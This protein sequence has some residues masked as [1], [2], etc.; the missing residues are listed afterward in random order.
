M[1]TII[2][3]KKTVVFVLILIFSSTY[4]KAQFG[5]SQTFDGMTQS[6]VTPSGV[7]N[8][9][10]V[11]TIEF[12]VKTTENRSN[13]TYWQRPSMISSA[14]SGGPSGDFGIT[15]DNGYVGIWSGLNS[16]GDNFFL[17][18]TV[19]IND[20]VWHH[21][22]AVNNGNVISLYVDGSF[23]GSVTSG[24]GLAT[25]AAP[26]AIGA[27]SLD[28]GFPG[29]VG[30]C[31]FFH[32][33]SIDEV[34]FS[35]NVR[36]TA[37]FTVPTTAFTTDANTVALY[38]LDGCV[39]GLVTDASGNNNNASPKNL[40]GSCTF[41]L[42]ASPSIPANSAASN[43]SKAE[44]FFDADPGFGSGTNI[45]VAAANDIMV[46]SAAVNLT[47]LI[48]GAHRLSVRTK[49]AAGHWGLTNTTSFF[50][51][52]AI[53][54]IPATPN[55]TQILKAEYFFD[56]DPGF[57][58]A[59][60]IPITASFD[61]TGTFPLSLTGLTTGV[62]RVFLRT[63]DAGGHWSISN[64]AT[65]NIVQGAPVI[66][67]TA[68]AT[69][70]VK[71]EYFIDTDPGFGAATNI[72][73]TAGMD[74]TIN[75]AFINLTGLSNGV[76]RIYTRT[77]DAAGHWSISNNNVFSIIAASF[78]MPSNPVP[79]NITKVEY[80]FDTDPGFGNGT[81]ISV[82]PTTDLSS[83]NFAANITLLSDAQH[84]LY[85]RTY[86]GWGITN[87]KTFIKGALVPL[88]FLSFNAKAAA[89]SV[90]LNWKTANE[91]NVSHFD[92]ER[93][94]D[95][96]I[97]TKIGSTAALNNGT[98]AHDYHFTD[99][100]PLQGISYY[101]IKQIDN[102]G[103]FK[104]SVIVAVKF[105]KSIPITIYPNPAN[106]VVNILF[107]K[108]QDKNT[109]GVLINSGGQIVQRLIFA[110]LQSAQLNV[111]NLASGVYELQISGATTVTQKIIIKH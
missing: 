37:N 31:N 39:S 81:V 28:F 43:V 100:H 66:P 94:A 56:T 10:T 40:T 9:K 95:S 107:D 111:M 17:S 84:T 103:H 58:A 1:Q 34:R 54:G 52:P 7:M 96:R 83:F 4:C 72:P 90:L 24:L 55:A 68:T 46:N 63:K 76:H 22:A 18:N 93:S 89:D 51:V 12:W 42:P 110:G 98:S 20:N 47:G 105:G 41:T 21:I 109:V 33:G 108:P 91:I 74:V 13:G 75:N 48:N 36:Y 67:A 16:G 15:T 23:T 11:F 2:N 65:F 85:V 26:L 106:D 92:I 44:Y 99:M 30:A 50:I 45:S 49:D 59:T 82:T 19:Q 27:S 3:M 32:G 71:A 25:N 104:Y 79:G 6:I 64:V 29:N 77:K 8:S 88:N 57:G 62:H 69:N 73:L 5:G 101:R 53:T 70:I 78:I 14:S 35:S 102:D 38:H 61:V 86:D 87:T 97:F 60:N 80:F